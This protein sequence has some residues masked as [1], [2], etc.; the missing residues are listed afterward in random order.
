MAFGVVSSFG[1]TG[2]ELG[3]RMEFRNSLS[4]LLAHFPARSSFHPSGGL[5]PI[6]VQRFVEARQRAIL[7]YLCTN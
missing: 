2:D 3:P 7:R 5:E 1:C 6:C 4:L